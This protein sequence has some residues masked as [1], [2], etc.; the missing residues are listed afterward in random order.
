MVTFKFL[1]VNLFLILCVVW[2]IFHHKQY[3]IK[4]EEL[5]KYNENIKPYGYYYVDSRDS[6]RRQYTV[7][8]EALGKEKYASDSNS[9]ILI[10]SFKF[11]ILKPDGFGYKGYESTGYSS[12]IDSVKF[13]NHERLHL[14]FEKSLHNPNSN[15]YKNPSIINSCIYRVRNDS[16]LVQN[17][18]HTQFGNYDLM[19]TKGIVLKDGDINFY[20]QYNY[21]NKKIT[22]INV[23]YTFKTYKN[24]DIPNYFDQ[25]KKKFWK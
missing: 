10:N 3:L 24:Y 15:L 9:L 23:T 16:I 11:F 18:F 1:V 7:E 19:E 14:S 6:M 17:Y 25:N 20:E 8:Q 22:K 13:Y 21:W 4:Q 12:T 5:G 2:N